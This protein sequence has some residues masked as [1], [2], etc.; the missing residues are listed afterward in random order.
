MKSITR[1]QRTVAA[2][3]SSSK[4]DFLGAD[5]EKAPLSTC[6]AASSSAI[7]QCKGGVLSQ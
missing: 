3:S 6:D 4:D 2:S 5:H 7:S 1:R